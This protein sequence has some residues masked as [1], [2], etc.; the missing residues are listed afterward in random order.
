MLSIFGCFKKFNQSHDPIRLQIQTFS[1]NIPYVPQTFDPLLQQGINS[2]Y[3][4]NHLYLT[5]FVWNSK[6]QLVPY[7]AKSCD[8]IENKLICN[9]KRLYFQDGTMIQAKH[10]VNS[11]NLLKKNQSKSTLNFKNLKYRAIDKLNLEFKFPNKLASFTNKLALVEI[12]PRKEEKFYKD[13]DEVISSTNYILDNYKKNQYILLKHKK[14]K[15]L[16]VKVNF[17]EDQA[18]ALRLYKSN[19]LNLL[20]FLPIRDLKNYKKS[21][22]LMQINM[23]RM[24]GIFFNPKLDGNLKKSLFH[25]I[26]FNDLKALYKSIGMPGCPSIPARFYHS[27]YCYKYDL[28]KAKLNLSKFKK[29][30]HDQ[31]KLSFS[32][33]GG[34]DIQRGM[35]WLANEWQK[36]LGLIV[37]IEPLETG[38]FFEKIR[39]KQFDIIRKGISLDSPTCLEALSYF[40]SDDPNNVSDFDNEDFDKLY[41]K[42]QSLDDPKAIRKTCDIA[43]KLLFENY[44]YIPLGPMY[45]SYLQDGKFEGWYINSLNIL[46]LNNLDLKG[47]K[48]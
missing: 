12:S 16:K 23:V 14:K 29:G 19:S 27:E 10:Y 1:Y 13:A 36:N 4:L 35:E 25:S 3:L 24:D 37:G 32:S 11:L 40:S 21:K 28:K 26:K 38:L 47:D 34:D 31:L 33:M 41:K 42:M 17:I 43:I 20:T 8:W 15:Y 22:E 6:N 2:R 7:G 5:L 18:T 39:S 48:I 44:T 46:N 45:F 9:L 30:N